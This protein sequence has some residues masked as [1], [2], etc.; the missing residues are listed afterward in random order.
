MLAL[1]SLVTQ[2]KALGV[3][4]GPVH[5]GK[6]SLSSH[7]IVFSTIWRLM[8]LGWETARDPGEGADKENIV[9]LNLFHQSAI[10]AKI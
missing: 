6:T 1:G 8:V 2:S 5:S 3:T 9:E 7:L 10:F 4:D